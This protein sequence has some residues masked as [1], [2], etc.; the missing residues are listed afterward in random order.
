M[1]SDL[2]KKLKFSY[3]G[4][5]YID[6]KLS[7]NYKIQFKNAA[8]KHAPLRVISSDIASIHDCYGDVG[9]V[10]QTLPVKITRTEI[11]TVYNFMES[12]RN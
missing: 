6:L 10:F 12:I 3:S 4:V 8:A 1:I 11:L 5:V 9:S 7:R 2:G